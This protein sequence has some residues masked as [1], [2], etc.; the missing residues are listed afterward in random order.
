MLLRVQWNE[1]EE[2]SEHGEILR[3]LGFKMLLMLGV[4]QRLV[5]VHVDES[6]ALWH[7][8]PVC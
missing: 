4:R 5:V 1:L 7:L 2:Q 8:R 3:T 6:A